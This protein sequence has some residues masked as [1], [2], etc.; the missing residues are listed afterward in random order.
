MKM[1][2]DEF[3]HLRDDRTNSCVD[4]RGYVARSVSITIDEEA[5]A[6]Y[7]GQVAFM[8]AAN[9][10]ARWSRRVRVRSPSVP[11]DPRLVFR[12]E[13]LERNLD[14]VALA[15]AKDADPFGDF[16]IDE[17]EGRDWIRVHVGA[18]AA[19]R[20]AYRI[21]G[22][23]WQ[24]LGGDAVRPLSGTNGE[25]PLGAALAACVGVAW[26][27]RVALGDDSPPGYVQLS[28][29]N[30]RGGDA[31]AQG[32]SVEAQDLGRVMLIGCGAVGSSIAYL[33]PLAGIGGR[34]QLIDGDLVD[35]T[36]LNRSPMFGFGDLTRSKCDVVASHLR[37]AGIDAEPIH[38]WFDEAMAR[39]LAFRERPDVVIPAANDRDVRR[40]VQHQVPPL[41]VYGTTGRDWQAFLGRHIPTAE[42][43]LV[44][45]FP[46]TA[47][48]EPRL[49]CSTG[50]IAAPSRAGV[51]QDAALPFLSA[52]AGV[53]A[54]AELVKT[55]TSSFPVNPNFACLD[56]RGPLTDFMLIQRVPSVGCICGQQDAV[57]ARLNGH[58][59]FAR[60]SG[61]G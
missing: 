35:T 56:F 45:R 4:G 2:A 46:T 26:A 44:C 28:L 19:P 40:L 20:G 39:G 42:D 48:G 1:D 61:A 3:Y 41:Q 36:N 21:H 55:A 49:A 38:A 51:S 25:V 22:Q 27:F 53:L 14:I 15:V 18:G 31:A 33:L 54:V 50:P 29:W 13:L 12:D 7:S 8:L 37:R 10:T 32:P 16:A 5:A 9:L 52:A 17:V 60:R 59:R 58:T 57:W 43:C 34:V 24:A 23:G 6:S 47:P 30:M 11:V